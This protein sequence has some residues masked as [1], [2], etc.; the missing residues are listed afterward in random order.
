VFIENINLFFVK[1]H[2][3]D[4][5]GF[6]YLQEFSTPKYSFKKLNLYFVA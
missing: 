6:F 3:L 2:S 5:N 1:Y 4:N